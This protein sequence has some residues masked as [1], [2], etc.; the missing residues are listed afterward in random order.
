MMKIGFSSLAC[1]ALDVK[2]MVEQASSMGYDGIELRGV[3]GELNLP[4]VP[5]LVSRPDHVRQLFQQNNVELVCLGASATLDSK[6]RAVLAQQRA[7]V[8]EYMELAARLACPAVRIFVGET[9]RSDTQRLALSRVADALLVLAPVAARLG[10]TLLLGNGGDFVRSADLWFL[11]DAVDHPNVRC[12]WNQ[13]YAW[14]VGERATQSIPLLGRKLG[15]IHLCDG[16][17]DERG[18][19]LGY[20]PLG[21]GDTEITRQIELLKGIAYDHY[22]LFE[23]PRLWVDSLAPWE[24]ILPAGAAFMRKAVDAKQAIL[25]AYKADKNAPRMVSPVR[26]PAT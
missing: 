5:E 20:E 7:V 14:T 1:P 22:L 25:T 6:K 8:I 18:V 2:T 9:Q 3:G 19:L 26:R 17:F 10:V 11:V 21:E 23:W 24:T 13:C 15:L 16:R 12:C 4:L